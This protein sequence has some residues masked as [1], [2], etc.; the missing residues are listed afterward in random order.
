MEFVHKSVLLKEAV[1]GLAIKPDGIYVDGT[2]GGG[3]HS[4]EILKHLGPK[5]R[6][7]CIDQDPEAIEHLRVNF[8]DDSRVKVVKSNFVDIGQVLD[9]VGLTKVNGVLLDLGVSSHQL[10]TSERGFSYHTDA[11]LDMRMSKEGVS[12]YDI[13]NT[14]SKEELSRILFEYAEEKYSR[15]IAAEI[16]KTREISPIETTSQ[17]VDVIKGALPAKVLRKDS[18]PARKTFQALRIAVNDELNKLSEALENILQVLKDRGKLSVITFHSLEDRIVKKKMKDW[19]TAC[20]CPPDFPICV[21]GKSA[22]VRLITRKP[23][24]PSEEEIRDNK[25]SRSAKLRV[26]EKV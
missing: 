6:L 10:D 17:L 15:L 18:H 4:A 20:T 14:L 23:I 3:G 11:A 24:L 2:A 1:D 12:A 9:S 7:I 25:R 26:C 16:V 19:S 22:S 21:C 8:A 5:G 13:V